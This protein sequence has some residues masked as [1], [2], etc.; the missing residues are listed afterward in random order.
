MDWFETAMKALVVVGGATVIF[1]LVAAAL[2]LALGRPSRGRQWLEAAIQ[3]RMQQ[4]RDPATDQ[5]LAALRE[6]VEHL[7]GD[8]AELQERLDFT[9]R[10]LAQQRERQALPDG[11]A[12]GARRSG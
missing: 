10:V 12:A 5:E 8:V 6:T 9:E 3:Q 4:R 2:R 7:G 1:G 11:G